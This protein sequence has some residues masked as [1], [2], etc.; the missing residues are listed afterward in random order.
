MCAWTALTADLDRG[1]QRG[2][3][4]VAIPERS[5]GIGRRIKQFAVRCRYSPR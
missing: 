3:F 5:V 4:G 1:A 2:E